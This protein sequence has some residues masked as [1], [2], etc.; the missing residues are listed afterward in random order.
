MEHMFVEAHVAL[1]TSLAEARSALSQSLHSRELDTHSTDAYA[2]G[3]DVLLRVGP[4]GSASGLSK[5]VRVHLLDERQSGHTYVYPLR[6]EATG[7]SGRLFPTLDANLG[8]TPSGDDSTVLSI[9]GR[10]EP[11]LG[12]LG[13]RLDDAVLTRVADATV[14]SM[15]RRFAIM[16]V[17]IADARRCGATLASSVRG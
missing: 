3:L 10:Y 15:L 14:R 1:P 13:R 12:G 4:R 9:V 8:L 11:P 17:A 2:D 16:V 5:E 6:W 7:T